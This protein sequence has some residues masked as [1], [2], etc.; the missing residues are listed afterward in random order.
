MAATTETRN[1]GVTSLPAITVGVEDAAAILG[2]SP[3]E[4]RRYIDAGMLPT[5]KLPS[6][7]R[8]GEASRR[9]LLAVEDLHAF[10]NKHRAEAAR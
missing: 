5:V 3:A 10:V 7:K 2:I 9:V 1:T 6:M 8:H 4:V